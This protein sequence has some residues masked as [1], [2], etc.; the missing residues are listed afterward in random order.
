MTSH[1]AEAGVLRGEDL[2]VTNKKTV[3]DLHETALPENSANPNGMY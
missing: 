2:L 1:Q 3:L